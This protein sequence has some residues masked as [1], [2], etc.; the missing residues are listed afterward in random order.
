MSA[1]R[2]SSVRRAAATACQRGFTLI[3]LMIVIAIVAILA[4]LAVPSFNEAILGS[5]LN[6]MANNFVASAHLARSEAIK[7]NAPVTLC[8]SSDGSTCSG[9]WKDGWVV[10]LADN[11]VIYTQAAFP[12]GFLMSE[13]DG[14]NTINFQ[15][16]GVGATPVTLTV[17]RAA[18][19]VGSRQRIVTLSATGRPAVKSV[20][21]ATTCS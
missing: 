9:A 4:T 16:T 17:C 15:S 2:L 19:T 11:T 3:E 13:A 18:P 14:K 10:L 1:A 5:K 12:A 21:G 20:S 6:S 7:R 8:A